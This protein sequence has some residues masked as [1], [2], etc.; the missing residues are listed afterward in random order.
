MLAKVAIAGS[1]AVCYIYAAELFPTGIRNSVVGI[2]TMAARGAG[3]LA[4]EIVL[5]VSAANK[6]CSNKHGHANWRASG[7]NILW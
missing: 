5:L 1:F 3:M 7:V 6:L 2:T 4:P